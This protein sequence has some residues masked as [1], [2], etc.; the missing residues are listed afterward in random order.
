MRAMVPIP[1][2]SQNRRFLRACWFIALRSYRGAEPV[3]DWQQ[4]LVRRAS[5]VAPEK[6]FWRIVRRLVPEPMRRAFIRAAHR[7]WVRKGFVGVR[8]SDSPIRLK[9]WSNKGDLWA[10]WLLPNAREIKLPKHKWPTD[11]DELM[12]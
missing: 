4:V 1:A 3:P 12:L 10:L 9:R 7:A 11:T 8:S 5:P 6:F 2:T